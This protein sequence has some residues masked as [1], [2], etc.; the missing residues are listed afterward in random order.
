LA[1]G[2]IRSHNELPTAPQ[3]EFAS[4]APDV[5]EGVVIVRAQPSAVAVEYTAFDLEPSRHEV[6]SDRDTGLATWRQGVDNSRSLQEGQVAAKE[7]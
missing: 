5:Q 6:G 2:S 4:E 3:W 1:E 7:Q